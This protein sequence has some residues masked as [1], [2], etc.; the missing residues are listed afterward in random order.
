[1]IFSRHRF[2][3]TFAEP[4]AAPAAHEAAVIEEELQQAS[5]ALPPVRWLPQR[6]E[7]AQPQ[8]EVF[9]Q[10]AA[11]RRA[12]QCVRDRSP[13]PRELMAM[14]ACSRFQPCQKA[15]EVSGLRCSRQVSR[16]RKSGT[17]AVR[18]M[19]ASLSSSTPTKAS[20]SSRWFCRATRIVPMRDGSS[21]SR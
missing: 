17:A 18:A 15:P 8:V 11:T 4:L 14:A 1:M 5:Q 3:R 10:Q 7:V 9:N 13:D 6:Q 16:T 20:R 21:G 19:A 12:A 2:T